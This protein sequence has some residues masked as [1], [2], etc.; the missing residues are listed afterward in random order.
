MT[1]GAGSNVGVV[2]S[3]TMRAY[4]VSSI[5]LT[6]VCIYYFTHKCHY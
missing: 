4:P 3:I 6:A 2:V 1:R 5:S